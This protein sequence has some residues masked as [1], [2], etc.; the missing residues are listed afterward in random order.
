MGVFA[1]TTFEKGAL[2]SLWGGKI[3][4]EAEIDA[5]S[6]THPEFATHPVSVYPGFFLGSTETGSLD[7]AELF[8]HSCD[9]N[10]GIR[11][12]VVLVAR[13]LIE[14]GEEI[15]FDYDTT[16]VDSIPFDCNC[17]TSECRGI[18]EGTAWKDPEWRRRN[19]GYL[20]LYLQDLIETAGT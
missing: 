2:I 8:N 16:E 20:S 13:R 6:K 17:G 9:P 11:G 4:T 14:T 18:I 15:T 12:Q 10:A 3:Y 19:A 7:E 5:L 1:E